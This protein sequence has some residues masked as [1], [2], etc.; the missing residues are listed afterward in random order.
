MFFVFLDEK[1]INT[2]DLAEKLNLK[3]SVI[4]LNIPPEKCN[5]FSLETEVINHLPNKDELSKSFEDRSVP[6]SGTLDVIPDPG[7]P[8]DPLSS[9]DALWPLKKEQC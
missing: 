5:S 4:G 7:K 1:P 6:S 9:I 2:T 3:N 8:V